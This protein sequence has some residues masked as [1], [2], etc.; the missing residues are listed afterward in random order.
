[1]TGVRSC[2]AGR[3]SGAR[4]DGEAESR[5]RGIARLVCGRRSKWAVLALWLVVPAGMA[6]LAQKLTDAQDNRTV[7]WLPQEAES[8]QVLREAEDI[9]PE[10]MPTVI[11][12][13]PESGSPTRTV[14]GSTRTSP[15]SAASRSTACA[16]VTRLRRGSSGPRMCRARRR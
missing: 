7:N 1:M 4:D 3:A 6:P 2:G 16:A 15:V 10:Q 13:A 11:M 12:C 5:G 14:S 8:T 9:R